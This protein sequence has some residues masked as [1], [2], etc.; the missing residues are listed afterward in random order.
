M[1]IP[2]EVTVDQRLPRTDAQHFEDRA[3]VVSRRAVGAAEVFRD[4]P[5]TQPS[6]Q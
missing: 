1:R 3:D 5:I 2:I 6:A 4:L